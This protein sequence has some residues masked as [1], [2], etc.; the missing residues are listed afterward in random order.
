MSGIMKRKRLGGAGAHALFMRSHF[1][2]LSKVGD[3]VVL[4]GTLCS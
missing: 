1:Q 2:S 4:A 3:C